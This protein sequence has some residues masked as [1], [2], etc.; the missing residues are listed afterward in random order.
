VVAFTGAGMSAESGIPTFRDPG[1]LWDRFDP[2][3]FGTWEGLAGVAVTR[4]EALAAFLSELRRVMARARPGPGHAA[5][6]RLERAGLLDGVITQNVDGLHQEAGN[7]RVIELHGSFLRRV[8]MVCG[9]RATVD[10]EAFL[11]DLDRAVSGLRSAFVASLA[12]LLPRC[13]ACGGPARPD[14]VAFGDAVLGFEEAEELVR[15][16]R[17]LLVIGTSGEVLPAA[18]LPE[19][20]QVAGA[21]VV[22]VSPEPTFIEADMRVEGVAGPTL[23]RLV[24]LAITIPDTH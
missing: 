7:R 5:L 6:V 8:C 18:R 20:G 17:T 9:S 1:G 4:P 16:C 19:E 3:E 22:E 14:F 21:T 24:E 23:P 10:R 13:G 11:D 12:S 2:D 15:G